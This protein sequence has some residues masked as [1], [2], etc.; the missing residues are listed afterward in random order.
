MT[1]LEGSAI[2]PHFLY[3]MF[4][5]CWASGP[6]A[7]GSWLP[8]FHATLELWCACEFSTFYLGAIP[9]CP[10]SRLVILLYTNFMTHFSVIPCVGDLD[11][12]QPVSFWKIEGSLPHGHWLFWWWFPFPP[13]PIN[14]AQG[15]SYLE[16]DWI[17]PRLSMSF[18][19]LQ[20]FNQPW[21][22]HAPDSW[23]HLLATP[24][25]YIQIH[26]FGL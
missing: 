8:R 13:T 14:M 17:R 19:E 7:A 15:S 4:W 9:G 20:A 2:R 26:F 11:I 22:S 18:M 10:D 3:P 24:S 16:A 23:H 12:L 25:A 5:S 21:N 1:S 6:F